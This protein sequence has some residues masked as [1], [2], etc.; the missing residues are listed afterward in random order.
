MNLKTVS[1]YPAN[2]ECTLHFEPI[3]LSIS[4]G[5]LMENI[6]LKDLFYLNS[7]TVNFMDIPIFK[8]LNVLSFVFPP[9]S[10]EMLVQFL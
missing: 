9:V 5:V 2:S 6:F 10:L 1:V 7:K 8:T 4:S 3:R